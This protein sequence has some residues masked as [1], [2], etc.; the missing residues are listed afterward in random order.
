MLY[1]DAFISYIKTKTDYINI[2]FQPPEALFFAASI[3][4]TLSGGA[5]VFLDTYVTAMPGT[6]KALNMFGWIGDILSVLDSLTDIFSPPNANDI[7][8]YQKAKAQDYRIEFSSDFS[9]YT[10][11]NI[12]DLCNANN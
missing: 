7:V 10:M 2:P 6:Q 12:L 5:S 1:K 11:E 8:I 9:E 3:K 4:D